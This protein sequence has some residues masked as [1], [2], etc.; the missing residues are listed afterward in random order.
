MEIERLKA[1]INLDKEVFEAKIDE[2]RNKL[3]QKEEALNSSYRDYEK[4][5][6]DN[7]LLKSQIEFKDKE[8]ESLQEKLR[9]IEKSQKMFKRVRSFNLEDD[10]DGLKETWEYISEV[11]NLVDQFSKDIQSGFSERNRFL[12]ESIIEKDNEVFQAI[13]DSEQK[14]RQLKK[15]NI[16][17][18]KALEL[19]YESKIDQL[20]SN[21]LEQNKEIISLNKKIMDLEHREVKLQAE[22][23]KMD[24]L[25]N[26][27]SSLRRDKETKEELVRTDKQVITSFMKQ[28]EQIHK[29]KF[30]L[31]QQVKHFQKWKK[32][33]KE[34][35][36]KLH[37]LYQQVLLRF[38][39]KKK[40]E[41]KKFYYNLSEAERT[42]F[43]GTM[44]EVKINIKKY[45]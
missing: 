5:C 41:I 40:D 14:I 25:E 10:E 17:V 8:F 23:K 1:K 20:K 44:N 18:R 15:E 2:L 4:V 27:I 38:V 39:K 32:E 22:K 30:E 34:D 33:H 42:I 24:A 28:V 35:K 19:D 7:K 43:L 9:K 3:E 16:K 29:T 36:I 13:Q 45:L 6:H 12:S 26:L 37:N 11:R 31:E 21:I